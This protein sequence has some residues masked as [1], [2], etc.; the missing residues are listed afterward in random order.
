M[1][2]AKLLKRSAAHSGGVSRQAVQQIFDKAGC[3]RRTMKLSNKFKQRRKATGILRKDLPVSQIQALYLEKRLWVRE[4]D[5]EL[6][7][8][9][10]A[11]RNRLLEV[12]TPLRNFEQAE[13]KLVKNPEL[14][15]AKLY[16][17]YI[18]EGKTAIEI[19]KRY[20]CPIS[21]IKQKIRK[22]G[23]RKIGSKNSFNKTICI[24]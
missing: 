14:T 22:Q 12:G 19:A 4:I 9:A 20:S 6:E 2:A 23:I 21:P 5:Q 7:C 1:K 18:V 24:L 17:L 15:K 11:I 8:S 13:W 16:R 3:R 10:T